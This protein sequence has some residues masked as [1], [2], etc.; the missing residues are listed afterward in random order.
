MANSLNDFKIE[1]TTFAPDLQHSHLSLK[2]FAAKCENCA[3]G[4]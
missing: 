3:N 2:Y 1:V 4:C